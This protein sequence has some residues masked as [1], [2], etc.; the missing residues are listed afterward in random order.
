MLK[1]INPDT[2]APPPSNFS[3]VVDVPDGSRMAFI[4]GQVAVDKDGNSVEDFEGQCRQVLHN[5]ELA[6]AAVDMGI[7]DIVRL[8]AFITD[9]GDVGAFRDVRDDW[10]GGHP[11][12]STLV[13]VSALAAPGWKVEIEAVAAC[14]K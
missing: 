7:T 6:L 14:A 5:L 2:L 12:A 3:H 10:S 13:V 9:A 4:S 8:N 1:F 11:A